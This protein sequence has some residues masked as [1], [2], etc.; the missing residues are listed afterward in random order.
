LKREWVGGGSPSPTHS[1]S[2]VTQ[3]IFESAVRLKTP[4]NLKSP[5]RLKPPVRL[6]LSIP[7]ICA[8]TYEW[9]DRSVRK[10]S[11]GIPNIPGEY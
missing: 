8:F 3:K 2:S 9:A 11:G 10:N 7:I 6:E 5:I 1:R 4:V